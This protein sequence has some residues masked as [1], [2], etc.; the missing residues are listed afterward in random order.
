MNVIF[1][2]KTYFDQCYYSVIYFAHFFLL[3][4]GVFFLIYWI[5]TLN[6]MTAELLLNFWKSNFTQ[7]Q[8]EG[9]LQ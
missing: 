7:I 3:D 8:S 2:W 1:F 4:F 9:G 5:Q 6:Y